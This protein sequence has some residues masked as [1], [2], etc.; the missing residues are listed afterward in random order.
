MVE[1]EAAAM[2]QM[3]STHIVPDLEACGHSASTEVKELLVAAQSLH[4]AAHAIH[5]TGTPL[6]KARL[7]RVLR[8]ETMEKVS[9]SVD[10][11][12]GCY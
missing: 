4:A 6:D 12:I 10:A 11:V 3:I 8:L 9:L 7:S 2:S 1:I 5:E